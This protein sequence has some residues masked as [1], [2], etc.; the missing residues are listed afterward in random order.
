MALNNLAIIYL[1]DLS[2]AEPLYKKAL[3]IQEKMLGPEHPFV[4]D[5][6]HALALVYAAK[7]DLAESIISATTNGKK[8]IKFAAS[9]SGGSHRLLFVTSNAASISSAPI[10][11]RRIVPAR[12]VNVSSIWPQTYTMRFKNGDQRHY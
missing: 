4:G 9:A 2:Q 7:S 6:N 10:P 8:I 3:T 12:L 1:G 5:T 11:R